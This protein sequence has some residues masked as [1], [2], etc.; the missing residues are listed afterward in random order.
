MTRPVGTR[1]GLK[2][3]EYPDLKADNKRKKQLNQREITSADKH[4]HTLD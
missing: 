3:P 4:P 1:G 2:F